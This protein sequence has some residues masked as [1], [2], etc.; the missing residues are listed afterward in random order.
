MNEANRTDTD[1]IVVGGGLAGLAAAAYLGRAN[2]SVIVLE[3]SSHVGGRAVTQTQG[4]FRFN[5]GPHALYKEGRGATI[6]RELDVPFGGGMP[7][8][9]GR[10]LYRGALYTLPSSPWSM[11]RTGLLDLAAKIEFGRIF[12]GIG[13]IDV[14]EIANVSLNDWLERNVRRPEVRRLLEAFARLSTY[15]NDPAAV[16]AGLVIGQLQMATKGVYYLDGGWQ[17]LVDGLARCAEA[18]GVR[19]V[20]GASVTTIEQGTGAYTVHLDGG[21]PYTSHSII[22]AAGPRAAA[23]LLGSSLSERFAAYA[24]AAVPVM[25]ATLDVGLTEL[26][27]PSNRFVLGI[28]QPLYLSVHSGLADL[29]P[30]GGAMIHV[31]MYLRRNGGPAGR[32]DAEATQIELEALLDLAQPGWREVVAEQRFLPNLT[33][34]NALVT[35]AQAGLAGRPGPEIAGAPGLYVA[36]DWVGPDGWLVDASLASAKSAASAII[37]SDSLT[38]QRPALPMEGRGVGGDTSR[39]EVAATW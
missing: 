34:V 2:R 25:A 37:Q 9:E 22:I 30:P 29:A 6:L 36:G 20:T 17:T 12:A 35:A 26:P 27:R 11:L 7:P 5:L 10:A 28:D 19:I 16:S 3:R 4:D 39:G 24:E 18:A 38:H 1:V 14:A 33:V 21:R 31:A 8:T 32:S 15:A 13:R 23:E